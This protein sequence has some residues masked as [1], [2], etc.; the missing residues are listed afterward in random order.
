MDVS[1]TVFFPAHPI[2]AIATSTARI[3][4]VRRRASWAHRLTGGVFW[5]CSTIRIQFVVD[6]EDGGR[7]DEE[8]SHD[9][10]V[11]SRDGVGFANDQ[12]SKSEAYRRDKR[13]NSDGVLNPSVLNHS[14]YAL[15]LGQMRKDIHA[16]AIL[17]EPCQQ[18]RVCGGVSDDVGIGCASHA[19][20][21]PC[22]VFV[23]RLRCLDHAV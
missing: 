21:H 15:S 23:V 19:F 1:V 22:G 20:A 9:G 11:T 6:A 7:Q 13:G 10:T 3:Y 16:Y 18:L 12:R 2:D 5:A 17:L 14:V 8:L 4:K